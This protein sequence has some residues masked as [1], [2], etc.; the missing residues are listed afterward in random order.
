[1]AR[2][3]W[4][5]KEYNHQYYHAHR[6]EIIARKKQ[7]RQD[8]KE[9]LKAQHKTHY[10]EHKEECNARH[11]QWCLGHQDEIKAYNKQWRL[12]H[13]DRENARC[14][15]YHLENQDKQNVKCR[16]RYNLTKREVLAHYSPDGIPQC[17]ECGI[18]DIDVLCLDHINND[19][20]KQRQLT[21]GGRI[22][23][24]IIKQQGFPEGFQTLCANCNL[25]KEL[26]RKRGGI[27]TSVLSTCS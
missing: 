25:K 27:K 26:E 12:K 21:R 17:T 22:P 15:Q 8:H 24:N 14:R 6:D 2:T 5:S 20:A 9:Q 18:A 13:R 23:Y 1:M 11:K 19:G 10:Q 3:Q 16:Q 4:Q 7:Y